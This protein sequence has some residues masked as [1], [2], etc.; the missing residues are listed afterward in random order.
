MNTPPATQPT[1]R[2]WTGAFSQQSTLGSTSAPKQ[3]PIEAFSKALTSFRA[4][5]SAK[6]LSEFQNTTYDELLQDLLRLQQKQEKTKEMMDLSRIQAFL[7]GM[8]Q[9][10]KTIEV[11]VNVNEIVCFVWGPVK[12][13]LL[14]RPPTHR[15]DF[16][17]WSSTGGKCF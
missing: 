16:A 7:E 12:F 17:N 9:L 4:R 8:Q 15:E 2:T 11:F 1:A 13:L 3:R 6:E 14:V 10:G 5:L